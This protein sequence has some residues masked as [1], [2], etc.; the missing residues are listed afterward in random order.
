MPNR[1][2][3]SPS[4][5]TRAMH[6]VR[7][8]VSAG[9]ASGHPHRRGRRGELWSSLAVGT[10]ALCAVVGAVFFR[11]LMFEQQLRVASVPADGSVEET[12]LYRPDG[13]GRYQKLVIGPQGTRIVGT[14]DRT[15]VPLLA[16]ASPG[17][18]QKRDLSA[19]D[20]IRAIG[21]VFR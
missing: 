11:G 2:I 10:V 18:G 12:V 6:G 17:P 16:E 4:S 7:R 19:S 5:T 8:P 9:V 20:R 15:E 13:T 14:I 3:V 21:A 1:T